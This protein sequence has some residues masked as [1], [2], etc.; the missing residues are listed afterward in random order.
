MAFLYVRSPTDI[1]ALDSLLG[2]YATPNL[3]ICYGACQ[4]LP[5][6]A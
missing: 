3:G 5:V 2:E 6:S 4:S 1:G